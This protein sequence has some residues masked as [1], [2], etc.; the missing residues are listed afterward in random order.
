MLA[1]ANC[2]CPKSLCSSI[3]KFT[4]TSSKLRLSS[5]VS[6]KRSPLALNLPDG[7]QL[8]NMKL[9][10][11]YSHNG[12]NYHV[13]RE[14]RSECG[15]FDGDHLYGMMPIRQA[16]LSGRRKV[17]ELLLQ[18]DNTLSNKKEKL[19]AEELMNLV[20]EKGIKVREFSKHD[21]NLL[22][23][24]KQHQGFVLRVSFLQA[25]KVTCLKESDESFKCVLALD[26]VE[27]PQNFGALIRTCH[28]LGVERI[29]IQGKKT[30]PLSPAVSSISMG[31][32]EFVTVNKV[33][34]LVKFLELS[35]KNGWQVFMDTGDIALHLIVI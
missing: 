9:I 11:R 15:Y 2:C 28:Y 33:D 4:I 19:L 7:R 24:N 22:T 13:Q 14:P 10:S 31:A 21:L 32:V 8:F 12:H 26:E 1:V 23:D 3:R 16:I 20:K 25:E 29:V 34:N 27:D 5:S 18:K 17:T 30:A 6:Q 35:K